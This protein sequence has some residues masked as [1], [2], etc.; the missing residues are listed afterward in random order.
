MTEF[1]G[2]TLLL[3]NT[4]APTDRALREAFYRSLAQVPMQHTGAILCGGDFNC[5][6]HPM[7]DRSLH[8]TASARDSPS[9]RMLFRTWGLVDVLQRDTDAATGTRD[10]ATFHRRH[11]TLRYSQQLN[12]VRE[13]KLT[14]L[15]SWGTTGTA[16]M[17]G[18]WCRCSVSCSICGTPRVSCLFLSVQPTS[19]APKSL[20]RQRYLSTID[21]SR[22]LTRTTKSTHVCLRRDS[23]PVYPTLSVLFKPALFQGDRYTR[24]SIRSLQCGDL[25]S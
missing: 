2:E 14:A 3:G 23:S 19:T 25:P 9:L 5:T 8:R 20:G 18:C 12:D 11:R 17:R 6:L 7:A 24:R 13:A 22:S 16:I 10:L 21:Q 15:T 1:H 4:Y